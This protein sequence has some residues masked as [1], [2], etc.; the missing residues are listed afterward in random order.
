LKKKSY[1]EEI[2]DCEGEPQA[3]IFGARLHEVQTLR[4]AARLLA[5]VQPMPHLFS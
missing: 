4:T 5:E 3:E 2:I 1:G